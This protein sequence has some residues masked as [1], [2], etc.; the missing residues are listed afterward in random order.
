MDFRGFNKA[1]MGVHE[2]WR[3]IYSGIRAL[4]HCKCED[5][6]FVLLMSLLSLSLVSVWSVG[7][8]G[9]E[10]SKLIE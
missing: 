7:P 6:C 10:G 3:F 4:Q 2:G 9:R 1:S 8:I 5:G